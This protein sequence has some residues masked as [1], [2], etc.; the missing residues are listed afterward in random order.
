M[1]LLNL[2]I[3]FWNYV[4]FIK[5]KQLEYQ[6]T[7]LVL[8]LKPV[9]YTIL[10]HGIMLTFYSRSNVYKYSFFPYTILEWNKLDKN[11]QQSKTIKA[12]RNCLLK[13]GRPTAKPV[14]NIHNL[15]GLKLL[16]RLRL[17]LSCLNEH[18]F[19]DN[20]RDCVNPLMPL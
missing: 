14:Y 13:I 8:F 20:F 4:L 19:N 3:G 2:D 17:G 5:S 18:R 7:F 9:I 6:D 10:I 15:T 1:N 12:F 11:I 16:T